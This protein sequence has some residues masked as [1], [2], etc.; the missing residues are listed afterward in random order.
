M[1]WWVKRKRSVLCTWPEI[2]STGSPSAVAVTKPVAKFD[3]PGPEVVR[4]T[5]G[6]PVILPTPAAM[7]AA[8]CSCRVKTNL[9]VRGSLECSSNSNTR[10]IL[11][12]GIPKTNLTSWLIKLSTIAFA[13]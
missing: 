9:G 3:A 7:K 6:F 2:A 11:A 1:L 10:S 12:P 5:P 13:P 8:F 4:T